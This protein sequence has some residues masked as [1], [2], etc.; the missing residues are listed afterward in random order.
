MQND[1]NKIAFGGI[2]S[3]VFVHVPGQKARLSEKAKPWIYRKTDLM[4]KFTELVENLHLTYSKVLISKTTKIL[5][6]STQIRQIPKF[7][8]FCFARIFLFWQTRGC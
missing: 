2:S 3:N 5:S 8:L 4:P 6:F 1:V 7:D